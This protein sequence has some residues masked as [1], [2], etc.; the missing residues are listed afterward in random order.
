LLTERRD[1]PGDSAGLWSGGSVFL[2]QHDSDDPLGDGRVRRIWGVHG[3]RGIKIID[4]ENGAVAPFGGLGIRNAEP[5][6]RWSPKAGT[7]SAR[8]NWLTDGLS[9]IATIGPDVEL[10]ATST[11]NGVLTLFGR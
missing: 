2:R 6:A 3:Q 11:Q 10:P 1:G 5:P 8:S 4:L 9:P 7:Y